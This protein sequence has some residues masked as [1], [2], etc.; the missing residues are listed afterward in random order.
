MSAIEPFLV[1]FAAG[2][3]LC[4]VAW[5]F[6]RT[7]IRHSWHWRAPFCFLLAAS[8]TPT[9]IKFWGSWSVVPAAS[10]A[11]ITFCGDSDWSI[12]FLFGLLPILGVASIIFVVWTIMRRRSYVA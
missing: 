3:L 10:I 2:A 5:F 11:P 8:I 6:V 7:R 12:G 4:G 9:A 1:V